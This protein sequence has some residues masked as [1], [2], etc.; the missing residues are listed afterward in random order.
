MPRTP[1]QYQELKDKRRSQLMYFGTKSFGLGTYKD[2]KVSDIA[3]TCKCSHGLFFHYFEDKEAFFSAIWKEAVLPC[4]ALPDYEQYRL[5]KGGKGL[6]ELCKYFDKIAKMD[7]KTLLKVRIYVLYPLDPSLEK[8]FPKL[9]RGHSLKTL[10][11]TLLKQAQEEGVAI[12][13]PIDEIVNA[14]LLL[15]TE[16]LWKPAAFHGGLVYNLLTKI[17]G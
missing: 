13:G 14:A 8:T 12:A 10:L 4:P 5:L 17:V 11:K 1:D 7:A 15:F 9:F 2:V 3:K 6:Q 16:I